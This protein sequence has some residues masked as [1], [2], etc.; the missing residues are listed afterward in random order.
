MM[1][2]VILLASFL[3]IFVG[4]LLGRITFVE[5]EPKDQ[6]SIQ[7]LT[8][9]KSGILME[10]ET[11][12]VLFE[13]NAHEKRS[14]A[15]M[16]KIMSILLITEAIVNGKLK[17]DDIITVSE[18]AASYGGSQIFLAENETMS[19]EDLYKGMVIASGNDATVALAE[20]VAGSE[21][22][23]V[24]LM[25]ER[26]KELGLQNTA[27][28]DPNGLTELEDGHYSTAYDM[29]V[30]SRH[31]LKQYGDIVLKYSSIYE[32][33]L[34]KGTDREFWLVNTNKLVRHVPGV[35][36]LK[37]GWTRK[38]GYNLTATMKKDGMRLISVVMGNSKPTARNADTMRLFNYG[39]S[40][41]QVNEFLRAGQVVDTLDSIYLRPRR[42]EVITKEAV[43]FVTKKG[44]PLGDYTTTF[45]YRLP[46]GKVNSGDVIGKLTVLDR[47]KVVAE[48]ELT[49][50]E[51]V[52]PV[53]L[54][55]LLGRTMKRTLLG[56]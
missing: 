33:Y 47:G 17:W 25:N 22:H 29:A 43:H 24:Q 14:P 20:A 11:G 2:R 31:L 50:N 8:D 18:N 45:T 51:T 1:K 15:S 56:E 26:A 53:G 52:Q 10:F 36:G 49:V 9:A 3:L 28:K 12:E 42:V 55:K 32:D 37:T 48:V 46:K 54:L 39:F 4:I 7:L 16:T 6:P 40:M 23:F 34:R 44:Q 13:Y 5:A 41:Y 35:D 19:V 27:F 38:S 21:E 30:L